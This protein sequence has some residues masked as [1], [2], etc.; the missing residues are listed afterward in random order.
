MRFCLS[1]WRLA[2]SVLIVL[3]VAAWATAADS[4]FVGK[5]ALLEDPEVAKELG[6]ADDTKAK[7]K[8]LINNREKEAIDK[9][10][11]LKG[12]PQAKQFQEMAPF[13]AESEKL[14][15]ALL[16]DA[17]IAKLD[18]LR[19]A[20]EGM[21]G[22]LGP[23]MSGKL[24]LTDDQKK[25]IGPLVEEYKGV[26]ARGNET[27]KRSAR[28]YYEKKIAALLTDAQRGTWEQ[29]SGTPAGGSAAP[30]GGGASSGSSSS[31][32]NVQRA[33]SG[34]LKV[35]EDGKFTINF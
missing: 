6:L 31:G 10:A 16:T 20:K 15:M 12:Q 23:D 29:L 22:V 26:M 5:L 25:E 32:V 34:E 17:Q 28:G 7:L 18:K 11:K 9:V 3:G 30:T 19:V 27:Q 35:T 13:A 4:M 2:S 21:L 8:E 24:Q 1:S 14:G 33:A